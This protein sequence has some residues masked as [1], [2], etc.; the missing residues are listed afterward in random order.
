MCIICNF[1]LRPANLTMECSKCRTVRP[2]TQDYGVNLGLHLGAIT[3]EQETG[4]KVYFEDFER[5]LTGARFR[6]VL[7]GWL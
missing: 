5:H 2:Q 7:G 3:L 1:R 4:R 6:V